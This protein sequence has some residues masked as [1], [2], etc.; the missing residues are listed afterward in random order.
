MSNA[1]KVAEEKRQVK[2]ANE[3]MLAAEVQVKAQAAQK[4][5]EEETRRLTEKSAIDLMKAAAFPK[6]SPE[7]K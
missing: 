5:A 2:L 6:N 3:K 1:T 4:K 7:K